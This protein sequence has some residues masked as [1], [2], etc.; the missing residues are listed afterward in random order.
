[1]S[2]NYV[3]MY[4]YIYVCVYLIQIDSTET[5]TNIYIYSYYI[6]PLVRYHGCGKSPF[7]MGKS[8]YMGNFP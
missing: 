8:P 7:S 1:M 4:V 5:H 3:Y 6:H 2:N